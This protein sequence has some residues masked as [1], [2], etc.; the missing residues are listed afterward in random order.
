MANGWNESAG[1]WIADLGEQGD[2][3]RRHVLDPFLIPYFESLPRGVVLDVGCGE[4]RFVRVLSGMGYLA[5]G[6]DPTEA[7][8]GHAL[9]LDPTG[10]YVR[11]VAEELPFGDGSFDFVLTYLS[12]IDIE[13]YKEAISEMAR[14]LV[15]SG[16]LIVAHINDFITACTDGWLKDEDGRKRHFRLDS[17]MD[18]RGEWV[19]WRGIRIVNFHRTQASMMQAFLSAGLRLTGYWQPAP[20]DVSE[21]E[22]LNY[23][24]A[25]W[26]CVMEWRKE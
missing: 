18:E 2:W 12:L 20:V 8:L 26:F 22:L 7:L 24:R 10:R 19:A 13:R 17:Y 6:L 23:R 1:A 25:P 21:E 4:G 3:S 9:S 11:G 16:R 15:P 5:A 14:V